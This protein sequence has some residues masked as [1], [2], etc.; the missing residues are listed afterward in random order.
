VTAAGHQD[1][2]HATNDR[3]AHV[4]HRPTKIPQDFIIES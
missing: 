3:H 1:Q 2:Q 4:Y